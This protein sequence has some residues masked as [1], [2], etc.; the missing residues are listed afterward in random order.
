MESFYV[1]FFKKRPLIQ[2][3]E[4]WSPPQ[5]RNTFIRVSFLPS[6]FLCASCAKEKSGRVGIKPFIQKGKPPLVCFP[7][8]GFTEIHPFVA[9]SNNKEFRALRGATADRGGS[10]KPLKRL[11]RNFP[12]NTAVNSPT[13]QNLKREASMKLP[14]IIKT[15]ISFPAQSNRNFRLFSYIPRRFFR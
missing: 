3:A 1:A 9:L 2:R 12:T 15:N 11:E 13:N 4:R 14:L 7:S 5:R 6:F 8:F 10:D